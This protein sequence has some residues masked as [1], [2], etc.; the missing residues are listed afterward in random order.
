M[1][2]TIIRAEFNGGQGAELAARLDLPAGAVRAYAIFA[3][4]FTCSKDLNATRRIAS[5]LARLGIAVLRFDFTGLGSSEGEFAST[6]FSSNIADIG[7]AAEWLRQHY[8][9]PEILIG[10][11]LGGAAV[12]AAAPDLDSVKAVA[13]IAAPANAEHVTRSFKMQIDDIRE[14]GEAQVTLGGRQF[15]IRREFLD[16]LEGRKVTARLGGMKKALLVLHSPMDDIVGIDNAS[17]IFLAAKHPKS[18]VSLDAADHLLTDNED[19]IFTAGMIAAWVGR[20]LQ[21]EP[22]E[23]EEKASKQ[24]LV[25]ET[26]NGNFQNVVQAGRH[27]LIAD[28]PE[29][30]GGL[31]SGPTPYDFL[32][33]G[34]GACTSMTLRMYAQRKNLNIGPI[35][36]E[37]DHSRVH[38]KDCLDCTDE[39]HGSGAHVDR[40]ER[41]ISVGGKIDPD[42]RAKLLQ[43]AEKCPVH[44]TLEARSKIDTGIE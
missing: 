9:A 15:T 32:A 6:D 23:T 12:L 13:T 1:A 36:V 14:T 37:V 41:R 8:A 31:D 26:M 29:G 10:H 40:F 2:K 24:V 3:H 33:I 5:E 43:I 19:A 22:P 39:E 34:L 18:F 30:S 28:E 21:A 20:Y 38:A 7:A 44:R 42:L 35:A 17:E 27:R 16:D 25:R 4:C 11:S